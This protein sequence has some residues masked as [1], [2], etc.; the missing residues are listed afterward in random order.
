[1][2]DV[3][4]VELLTTGQVAET[5][6]VDPKTVSKWA[7]AGWLLSTETLGG[8]YRFF[9][10]EVAS[11]LRGEDRKQARELAEADRARLRGEVP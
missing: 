6:R 2:H 1:V 10:V 7:K 8:H 11:L 5:F 9:A 3:P 4:E